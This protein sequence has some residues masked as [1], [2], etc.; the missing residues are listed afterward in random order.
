MN[1][2]KKSKQ[3]LAIRMKYTVNLPCSSLD[4]NVFL[5]CSSPLCTYL[6]LISTCFW[7][8][9]TS[10]DWWASSEL[11]L[12]N[13]SEISTTFFSTDLDKWLN[14][15]PILWNPTELHEVLHAEDEKTAH[16]LSVTAWKRKH[17][18]IAR[19]YSC[20]WT[21][22]EGS[23]ALAASRNLTRNSSGNLWLSKESLGFILIDS[24]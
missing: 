20:F 8:Y 23:I 14:H 17:I 22:I 16:S 5:S 10:S 11:N 9:S 2:C 7:M 6:L 1:Q 24:E 19:K 12:E 18:M 21:G 15:S 13:N 4:F 3:A